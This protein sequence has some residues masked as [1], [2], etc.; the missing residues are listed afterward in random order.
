MLEAILDRT[1]DRLIGFL[2]YDAK[3]Y[4][5]A[6]DIGTTKVAVYL[7]DLESGTCVAKK[8][9]MNPQIIYGE[10]VVNRI[11]YAV[12]EPNGRNVLQ[13]CPG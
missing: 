5:L 4:G 11:A 12:A 10:D 2:P 13:R 7:L 9:A 8:G 1:T 3:M 6:F